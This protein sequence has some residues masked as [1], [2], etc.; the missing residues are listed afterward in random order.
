MEQ[1]P[2]YNCATSYLDYSATHLSDVASCPGCYA[3]EEGIGTLRFVQ[4]RTQPCEKF[5]HLRH[6][7]NRCR[8]GYGTEVGMQLL[9]IDKCWH[10]RWTSADWDLAPNCRRNLADN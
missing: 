10:P 8:H 5:V 6:L 9:S 4:G 1:D 3:K 2:Q 7:K